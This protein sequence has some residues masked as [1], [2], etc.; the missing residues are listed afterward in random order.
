MHGQQN[1]KN[2]TFCCAFLKLVHCKHNSEGGGY[3]ERG[4]MHYTMHEDISTSTTYFKKL[5]LHYTCLHMIL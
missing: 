3:V 5:A 1:A 2:F 4:E